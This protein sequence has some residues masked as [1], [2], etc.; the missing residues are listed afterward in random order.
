VASTLTSSAEVGRGS[1]SSPGAGPNVGRDAKRPGTR[2]DGVDVVRGLVMVLMA[3]DHVRVYSGVPAGGPEPAVF[4]TRW[5]THFCAPAFIFLAGS[6][7]FLR[8]ARSLARTRPDLS[9]YLVVRGLVLI[10]LE[11]T[12]VRL[13]WTFNLESGFQMA[14]VIW[15][16]GWSMIALAALVKLPFAVIGAFGVAIVFGHNLLDSYAG[17]ASFEST[18]ARALWSILYAAFNTGPFPV[19]PNGPTVI[20]LYSLVPWVGVMAAGYAFGRILAMPPDRRRRICGAIGF[21]AIALFVLLRSFNA[22]GD[23]NDWSPD[24]ALTFL[25][26]TKYPASLLFLLMTLGPTIALL[27]AV[28]GA[29][30]PVAG[31]LRLFGRVPLFFYLLHIPLIHA[32]A[33][34]VSLLRTGSANP[35]LFANHPMAAG[36][37]PNGYTWSLPLLYAVWAISIALLYVACRWYAGRSFRRGGP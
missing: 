7:A 6:S 9:R 24:A 34:L 22:Y 26:T 18:P 25:N 33:V 15:V 28:D 29:Q 3:I 17:S 35:W 30:G 11:L 8:G 16:I 21:G 23:P 20:V 10:A 36:P 14:G 31:A 4:F 2:V 37:P 12:V 27:P 19:W 32:L 13:A 1:R 5:V